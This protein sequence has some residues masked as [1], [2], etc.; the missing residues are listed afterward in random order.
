MVPK[1]VSVRG[2]GGGGVGYSTKAVLLGIET[3]L[4]FCIPFL[5]EKVFILTLSYNFHRTRY[6]YSFCIP[7]TAGKLPLFSGSFSDAN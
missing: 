5:K 3:N 4:P 6:M 7:I 1:M 2:G